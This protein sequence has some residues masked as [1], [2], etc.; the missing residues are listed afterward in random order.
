MKTFLLLPNTQTIDLPAEFRADD[1]RYPASLVAHFLDAFTQQGDTVFDP[2]AGFGTTLTVAEAMGR[3]A[4]GIEFDGQRAQYARSQ[5]HYPD[6]IIHGD[7]RIMD[8]YAVPPFD[9]SMTSPPYMVKNGTANPFTA[10]LTESNGYAAYLDDVRDIYASIG[11]LMKPAAHAVIEVSNLKN[12]A[13]I[14]TLAWDIAAA[15]STVLRFEGEVVVGWDHY[16]YGYDHSYCL[17]F[18]RQS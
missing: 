5:M 2:F 6:R 15:V 16:A 10:Y 7:A 11:R 8:S 14:T 3:S 13:G 18:S 9:F 1:V 12:E 4:Y 17:I